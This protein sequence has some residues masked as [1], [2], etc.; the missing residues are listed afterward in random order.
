MKFHSSL[1]ALFA[2]T[3]TATYMCPVS[4]SSTDAATI[5][6]AM[7]VQKLLSTYYAAIPINATFFSTL[8]AQPTTDFLAN[9]MGLAVQAKLGVDALQQLAMSASVQPPMCS[10]SLPPV[11]DAKSHLMNAYVLEA[12]MC[13]T[14]IG[15]ADYVQSPQ[16]ALL[17][18]RLAA[19]HGIHAAYIA[20]FM[21]SV[22]FPTNSTMLTPAFTPEMVSMTGMGVGYLGA[23]LNNCVMPPA[24]PCGGKAKIGPLGVTL[25]GQGSMNVMNG[26]GAGSGAGS[27]AGGGAATGT[28]GMMSPTSSPVAF[29]GGAGS[30]WKGMGGAVAAAGLTAVYMM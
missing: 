10:Y 22:I 6:F 23:Y 8:P 24:A 28:G 26:T 3:A 19:E 18:A 9:T 16:A 17:M 30:M 25:T 2:A 27:G 14:F 5:S 12:T 4:P 7:S 21:Q 29:T 20:S 15:L 1:S 13:G 11:T